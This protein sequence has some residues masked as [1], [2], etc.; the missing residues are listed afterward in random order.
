MNVTIPKRSHAL[1]EESEYRDVGCEH[2]SSCLRCPLPRCRYDKAYQ[3]QVRQLRDVA[4][5]EA[6]QAGRTVSELAQEF[7]VSK[8]TIKR[9]LQVNGA[10]AGVGDDDAA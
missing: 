4:I 6:T 8:K 9:V 2:S 10:A 5:V 7:G 3:D 1:P